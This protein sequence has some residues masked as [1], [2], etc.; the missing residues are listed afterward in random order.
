MGGGVKSILHALRGAALLFSIPPHAL[1]AALPRGVHVH[2][3]VWTAVCVLVG[4]TASKR[5]VAA[6][7]TLTGLTLWWG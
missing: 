5:E 7:Q 3:L 4:G 6:V 1:T 2:V